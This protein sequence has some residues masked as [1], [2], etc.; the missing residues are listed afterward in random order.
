MVL[1]G[2]YQSGARAMTR[3]SSPSRRAARELLSLLACL[4]YNRPIMPKQK[5]AAA[6]LAANAANAA[7][8]PAR[9]AT[10]RRIALE[11]AYLIARNVFLL[12]NL[13]IFLV[14]GLLIAFGATREGIS[15][16]AIISINI[17]LGIVQDIQAWFVLE[18]LQLLT[19]LRVRRVTK[20]GTEEIVLPDALGKGDRIALSLGEQ[21]PCDS[22]LLESHSLE[23]S[24]AML[25]GESDSR[26][27][28]A[29]DTLLAGSI[30]TAGSGI[31]RVETVFRESSVAKMTARIKRYTINESPVQKSIN[32]VVI[33]TGYVLLVL[34]AFI[35]VHGTL[36]G[37]TRVAIVQTIGAVAAVLVPQGLVVAATLLFAFG[38]MHF[39]RRHVLLREV[40]AT[41][42][43]ARIKNLC[44]DKTGTLTENTLTVETMV[45][46]PGISK[47]DAQYLAHT[48]I[49]ESGDASELMVALSKTLAGVPASTA[50]DSLPFS[51]WRQYGGVLTQTN[52]TPLAVLAGTPEVFLP[53]IPNSTERAWLSE[54]VTK[55]A[56]LGK[57]VF[58]FVQSTSATLPRTLENTTLSP[59]AIYILTNNLR[60]GTRV[61]IDFFQKRGVRV[62]VLSGDNTETIR[63]VS[64][65]AGIHHPERL[66]TGEEMKGWTQEDFDAR[67]KNY[68]IFARIV[69]EQKEKIIDAL[70]KDGFTAMVGDG[71]NDALAIKKADVGVA[72]F[73]GTPAT[74]QIA[75][76]VLMHN[77]FAELPSGVRLADSIIENLDLFGAI[78][79]NQT[80]LGFFLFI[81]LTALGHPFPFSPLNIAFASYFAIGIP[82]MIIS[83]WAI[84]PAGEVGRAGGESYVRKIAPFAIASATVSSLVTAGIVLVTIPVFGAA[85][86]TTLAVL[87]F[88]V[89]GFGFFMFAPIVFS[90]SVRP[91]R[92]WELLGTGVV[93]IALAVVV[94]LIPF[95]RTFFDLTSV[96]VV[97]V[98]ELIPIF[99]GYMI[100]QYVLARI[101]AKKRRFSH[102]EKVAA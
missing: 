98:L 43:L 95:A 50:T 72:M 99:V 67:A 83:Y 97:R 22:T 45:V 42:K 94:F 92:F 1:S 21:I 23:I 49:K 16:G 41:E 51:S 15:L 76:V 40:N 37:E 5:E 35:A 85:V 65:A 69:P 44:L 9:R 60:D 31:A 64:A 25:T 84:R 46:P 48:Y 2:D 61:T 59:L 77:S 55:E 17:V 47:K 90:S 33:Y 19:A 91:T 26:A 100:V 14:V 58:C 74:R 11:I 34:I 53:H 86:A 24:E 38:G 75:A 39:Y 79:F 93:E 80:L 27:R 87:S 89:C 20:D 56:S 70:K 10:Y 29:R 101:F 73:D 32:R 81:F 8:L 36:I 12:I 4:C 13:I 66:I 68:T 78:F 82:G 71:A 102:L 30:V 6:A 18:R 96:P 54:C 3:M 63:A 57:R 28:F 62:R 7:A 88:A 52:G